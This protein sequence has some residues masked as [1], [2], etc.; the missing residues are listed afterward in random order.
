MANPLETLSIAIQHHRAGQ[1]FL[2][3]KLYHQVIANTPSNADAWHLLGAL[4]HQTGRHAHAIECI[5]RAISLNGNDA[6]YHCNLGAAHRALNNIQSAIQCYQTALVLSPHLPEAHLNLGVAY[7]A[8]GDMAKAVSFYRRALELNPTSASIYN[9]LGIALTQLGDFQAAIQCYQRAL[10]LQPHYAEAVQNLGNALG[11]IGH[12]ED[13]IRC[14]RSVLELSPDNADVQFNMGQLLQQQE[15]LK[16]A[17]HHYH[18]AVKLKPDNV[19]F[20]ERLGTALRA[21]GDLVE[22]SS[23]Y[24]RALALK[25][26]L[27]EIHNNLAVV[28]MEQ[29]R[30]DD[31]ILSY[32]HAL[33]LNPAFAEAHSN[34]GLVFYRQQRIDEAIQCYSRSLQLCPESAETLNNLG[35]AYDHLTKSDDAVDCYRRALAFSPDH[36][37]TLL[38]YAN[39]QK[40]QGDLEAAIETLQRVRQIAPNDSRALTLLCSISQY[41][42]EASLESLATI[43]AEYDRQFALP[44]RACWGP[45]ANSILPDRRLKIGFVSADLFDHPIGYLMLPIV[46]HLD[47]TQCQVVCFANRHMNDKISNELRHACDAWHVVTSLTDDQL[48]TLIRDEKIDILIDLSGHTANHRLLTFARKPAPIQASW[49]GYVGPTGLSAIE[50]FIADDGLVSNELV[51]RYH[52]RVIRLSSPCCYQLPTTAPDVGPLPALR[53]GFVTFGS[54]NNPAKITPEVVRIWAGILSRVPNSR[55]LMKFR[56]LDSTSV[57]ERFRGLFAAEGICES[58]IELQPSSSFSTMLDTYNDRVDIALD[59]FPYNGGTTTM[60]ALYMGVPVVTFPGETVAS[61]QSLALLRTIGFSDT[62][63][64]DRDEYI[65]LSVKLANDLK[66]LAHF[67]EML[68]QLCLGSPLFDGP[69]FARGLMEKLREVWREWVAKHSDERTG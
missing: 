52:E 1:W 9:N 63:A 18:Q 45:F 30:L 33:G 60:L 17:I 7:Q 59:P 46:R 5:E 8:Q 11:H 41:C 3:E 20:L 19:M 36:V 56:W 13:A 27:A 24:R 64:N 53:N 61:R 37:A 48:A 21:N 28:L 51:N 14:Y 16:D 42:P 55:L 4:A 68:R 22:A 6:A 57:S 15:K 12:F 69:K 44:F 67:R 40:D 35:L 49:M 31:A 54:F 65:A 58:R 39:A 66:R 29:G 38:N 26:D 62:I 32:S 43:H 10:E 25:P 23:C 2:A 50:Y 34:L 47:R